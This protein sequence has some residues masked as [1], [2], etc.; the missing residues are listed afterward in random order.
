MNDW[1][2]DFN[3]RQVPRPEPSVDADTAPS[4]AGGGDWSP[5][6]HAATGD[7]AAL[8]ALIREA[9]PL[10]VKLAAIAAL[11]TE[12]ALKSAE[13]EFRDHDRRVHRLAKQRYGLAVAQREARA[14]ASRLIEDARRLSSEALI[15]LNYLV[16]IDRAW[17]ALD[18]PLLDPGQRDEYAALMAHMAALASERA[19]QPLKLKRWTEQAR[20][21]LASLQASCAAAAAGEPDRERLATAGAAA[22][23]VIDAAP[24][25]AASSTLLDDLARAVDLAPQLDERLAV[26]DSDARTL[27]ERWAQLAPLADASLEARLQERF[28]QWQQSQEQ[29]RAQRRAEQR[30]RERERQ[31]ALREQRTQA[32]STLLESAEAALAAGHLAPTHGHLVEID[33]LLAGGASA[34]ALRGRIDALQAQVAQLEGWQH[35]SGGR[36]RDE[37]VQQAEELAAATGGSGAE[38]HTVKLSIKQ[39]ADLIDDMRARWKELDRLGG[40][41]SRTLW[42]RFDAALKTAHE[43]VVRQ[44]AAQRAAREQNQQARERLL[45]EWEAVPLP[46]P[47]EDGTMPDWRPLAAALDHFQAAWRK[48]GPIEHTVP[49]PA[50]GPLVERVNAAVQRLETPLQDA[51]R[52]A[53]LQRE[54]LLARARALATE[55]GAG[56][57][58]RDLVD[59]ARELQAQWQQQA[60]T[61]PLAR[62]DEHA[63]WGEFK[64]AIDAAF[65]ARE[66]AFQAREAAF[67]AQG[68]E[69]A[70]LIG[71]LD[72]L[73]ADTPAE[74]LKRTLAEVDAL[75]QRVGP[76]PRN[77]APALEARF[78]QARDAVRRRLD[79]S[80]GRAWHATCDALEAK[81]AL[82]DER[83]RS[84]DPVAATADIA[85]RWSA[86]PALPEPL[87]QALAQ[88]AGLPSA[89]AP[90]GDGPVMVPTDELLLQLEAAWG[91]ASPPAFEAARR[92]LKLQAMKA[93]LETRRPAKAPATPQ[94][95]LVELLRRTTLDALQRERLAAIV[96]ALRRRGSLAAA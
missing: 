5:R 75:W 79:D 76:A 10:D 37:L 35:W 48:L 17:Q 15:P 61:M 33:R 19:D 7:D 4:A 6:L 81:L 38:A 89:A 50:R 13:R 27:A 12:E 58:G 42:Q 86:L 52:V 68:A 43:P 83:A 26:L 16:D 32:L 23:A 57:L 78:R 80:A 88:H 72:S 95:G 24:D 59:K 87:E 45:A 47:A 31:H 66:A 96:S 77:D 82:C 40:A 71:R 9:S 51:R 14:Q 20:D 21:A 28:A 65:G 62:A 36:A 67:R 41:T 22:R 8:L 60:R 56:A 90:S 92:L 39:R 93:A 74:Q 29:W 54:P 91:L 1:F 63:L 70:A 49:H 3:R 84:A 53:R 69:R 11:A 30:A 94:Q 2:F 34:G 64:T 85:L 46:G 73:G 18:I 55:V 25:E 44:A